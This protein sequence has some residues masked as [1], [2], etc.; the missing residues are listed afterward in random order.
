[1]RVTQF[2]QQQQQASAFKQS[3]C[4]F[5]NITAKQWVSELDVDLPGRPQ[6]LRVIK[7][8]LWACC[9]DAGIVVFDRE[10]RQQRVLW[11]DAGNGSVFD[12]AEMRNGDVVVAT[13]TG[14]YL[15]RGGGTCSS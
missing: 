11:Q 4:R 2:Q 5:R 8:Q 13:D 6:T 7:R 12:V 9:L 1:M 3:G 14:L 15:S 10:L